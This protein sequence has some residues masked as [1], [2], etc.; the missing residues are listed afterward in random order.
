MVVDFV[1][2]RLPLFQPLSGPEAGV[3]EEESGVEEDRDLQLDVRAAFVDRLTERWSG[4]TCWR[5]YCANSGR[6]SRFSTK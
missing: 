5:I 2:G 3:G 6:L 1:F 4:H